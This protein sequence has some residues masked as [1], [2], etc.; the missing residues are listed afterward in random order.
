METTLKDG[1]TLRICVATPEDAQVILAY[2][3]Q[4]SGESTFL[5]FGPGEFEMTVEQEAEFLR[6]CHGSVN[7][8]YILGFIDGALVATANVSASARSR[9]RHCAEFGM[10]VRRSSWGLGIG[11]AMLDYLIAWARENPVLTKFDLRVRADNTRAISLYRGRG[12]I[13]EGLLR[14]QFFVDGEH[15]DLI[16]MGMDV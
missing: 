8:T 9:L 2:I 16:A 5:T 6:G 10:S 1:Q 14:K 11:A 7:Q 13:E 12:F 15:Y 3:A 4:R